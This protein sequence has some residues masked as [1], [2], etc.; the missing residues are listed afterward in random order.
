M[1]LRTR[2]L[3][4]LVKWLSHDDLAAQYHRLMA[5]IEQF[6]EDGANIMIEKGWLEQPPKAPD[7]K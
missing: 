7:R 1:P 4:D 2:C 3:W 5:E 6:A